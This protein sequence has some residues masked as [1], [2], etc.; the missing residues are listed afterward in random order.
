MSLQASE[1]KSKVRFYVNQF[2]IVINTIGKCLHTI[3]SA[4]FIFGEVLLQQNDM[5]P[6]HD[7]LKNCTQVHHTPADKISY[8]K[9]V[10]NKF[11]S[12]R[13]HYTHKW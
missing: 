5:S 3:I 10:I 12:D 6:L 9:A 1:N 8:S 4:E 13:W 2:K 7:T 11:H